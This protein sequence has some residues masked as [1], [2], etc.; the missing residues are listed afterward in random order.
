MDKGRVEL[1]WFPGGRTNI[2]YNALDRN[3]QN[4]LG[5]STALLWEGNDPAESSSMT[6]AELLALVNQIANYLIKCKRSRQSA[7]FPGHRFYTRLA[8]RTPQLA[9]CPSD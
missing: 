3:I 9:D 6:Y 7:N 1:S 4:G 2:C 8:N 5:D